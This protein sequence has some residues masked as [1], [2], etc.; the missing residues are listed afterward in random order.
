MF[1]DKDNEKK[2]IEMQ[3]KQRKRDREEKRKLKEIN[4]KK[5]NDAREAKKGLWVDPAPIP[6]WVYRKARPSVG[7]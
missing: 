5:R 6:P 7:E 3:K 2:K 1:Q 4:A